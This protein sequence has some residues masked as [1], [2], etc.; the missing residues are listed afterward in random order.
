MKTTTKQNQKKMKSKLS[1]LPKVLK[2]DTQENDRFKDFPLAHYS[3]STFSK[4][5][6]NPYMFL[7]NYKQRK[8]F[9]SAQ[10]IS[11]I[12]GKAVHAGLEA[13]RK[14]KTEEKG[15]VAGLDII[16]KYIEDTPEGYIKFSKT[17]DTKAKA[18][19]K[20]VFAFNAYNKEIGWREDT[21]DILG[22]EQEIVEYIKV[23]VNGKIV[24]LPIKLKG[25]IDKVIK[26]VPKGLSEKRIS[27]VDYKIVSKFSSEDKIDG[28]KM[29]QAV[30]YFFL[31]YVKY[32]EKPY[33]MIYQEI[34]H[35]K[36]KDTTIPQV[37]E[38]E[39][40]YED[41][42]LMFDFFYRM[43]D[44]LTKSLNEGKAVYV[45]NINDMYDADISI[46][47]YTHRLDDE[48]EVA[49]QMIEEQVDTITDLLK[50]KL[51]KKQ[52]MGDIIKKIESNF[53]EAKSINYKNMK[54]EDAIKNKLL[55]LG[56]GVN[57][58]K[59]FKGYT[60]NRYL[61]EIG[62]ATK[63]SELKNKTEDIALSLGVSSVTVGTQLGMV[64]TIFVD[65]PV[66]DRK[67]LGSAPELDKKNP[68]NIAIGVDA[69][70][71]CLRVDIRETP[72]MLIA[73]ASG[74]GK[75]IFLES[76]INQLTKIEEGSTN[77]IIMDP[78]IVEFSHLK[79]GRLQHITDSADMALK[80][81]ELVHQM[82][83]RYKTLAEEKVRSIKDSKKLSYTF[84]VIDEFGDLTSR[85]GLISNSINDSIQI[86]S[87]KARAV[88]IH[89]IIAS[90]R[91]STKIINGDIK[92][93]FPTKVV[94]K[95]AKVTDSVIIIDEKGA[96]K[97]LGKGDMLLTT[98][99][100]L[101]RLQGYSK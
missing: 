37:K 9:D 26:R 3:Y 2:G 63:L 53:A 23:E 69:T 73:G 92:A 31:A 21:E 14:A 44:D 65:I 90:Q 46:I 81:E 99:D 20:G 15:I 79:G 41:H 11:G 45:P 83:K 82:D 51:Q 10:G 42:K 28:A 70:G 16:Q 94:F 30:M 24:E 27:P 89:L 1:T 19:E 75:S 60:I 8:R 64:E 35:S 78:K 96:E 93:N 13:Y 7:I 25:F 39:M 49:R 87:Q 32:G 6:T 97:L 18:L 84:V 91:V 29:I 68:F 72:H 55:S 74:S 67:F 80:L 85:G 40:V 101:V 59:C 43:Y 76:I 66:K 4:F 54:I 50:K 12:L 95:T 62:V 48:E 17:I 77:I 71:K 86:L 58:L 52:S 47:A 22:L 34:K 36:N 38:Y 5:S 98:D 100:G 56:V 88:G 57:Y 33:S 61:F